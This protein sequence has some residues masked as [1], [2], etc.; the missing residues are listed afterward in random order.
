M[1]KVMKFGGSSVADVACMRS[2]AGRIIR[3]R[4]SGD[5]T[6]VVVSAMGKTTNQL[7]AMAKEVNRD[8]VKREL[9]MMLS[10]GEQISIAMLAMVL[11]DMGADAISLTGYQ[12][13]IR[14]TGLHTK[15]R[16]Q[17]I[18]TR[19][20]EEHL[21][22]DRIV[23]V[24]GFQGYNEEGEITTLGRGGSDTSAVALAAKLGCRCEIYTDVNGVYSL[25]PRRYPKARHLKQITYEEMKEMADLGAKVLEPRAVDIAQQFGVPLYVASSRNELPG[26]TISK[27]DG[28]LE[29]RSIT[30]MSIADSIIMVTLRLPEGEQIITQLFTR[31]ATEEIN[32]D[33]ISQVPM[34]DGMV[35]VSFT[36]PLDEQPAV[37]KIL[38]DL[39]SPLAGAS[40]E[41]KDDVCRI[42][43]I[44]SGM[45]HQTGVAARIFRI[46]ADSG[47]SFHLVSTSEISISYTL[48]LRFKDEAVRLIA[49]AFEL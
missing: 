21:A 3:G 10:T 19:K 46:F 34:P 37:E 25:D 8:P 22:Q 45:R 14:T 33:I 12:A 15:S 7:V 44:G 28:T 29:N 11:S 48:D 31:L 38:A 40:V 36:A 4:Q 23:V 2:I 18:D 20:I 1:R 13:G 30:G 47:I 49:E 27:G 32:I 42:S 39:V 16:I 41:L 17:D 26:T 5:E 9:D 6:V 24:A 43:V 35:G